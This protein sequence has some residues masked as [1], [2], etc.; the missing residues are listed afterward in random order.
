MRQVD[1]GGDHPMG[2]A[3]LGVN[4]RHPIVTKGNCVA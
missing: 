4:E 3:I 1:S 2:R